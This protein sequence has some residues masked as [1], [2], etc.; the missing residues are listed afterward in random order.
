MKFPPEKYTNKCPVCRFPSA[1]RP[2]GDGIRVDCACCGDFRVTN[3]AKVFLPQ[4]EWN[5]EQA[6]RVAFFLRKNPGFEINT[7]TISQL[8]QLRSLDVSEKG[9]QLLL[10]LAAAYPKPGDIISQSALEVP[11]SIMELR[12]SKAQ[13]SYEMRIS[14]DI[15]DSLKMLAVSACPDEHQLRWLVKNYLLDLHY[16]KKGIADGYYEISL[17]GWSLINRLNTSPVNSKQGFVAMPFADR[18]LPLFNDALY[19]GI[20]NAGYEPVRIDR[21]EHNNRIDDEIIAGI[22]RSR[23]VVADLSMHRGGIYFEAGYALGLGLP[24]VWTV[25]RTAL[26][27]NEVHFDNRQYN[28]LVWEEGKYDD[29][30]RRLTNRIEATIG[31]PF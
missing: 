31:R 21:H 12:R 28:F 14:K 10:S 6:F 3:M 26:D 27:N 24:V 1:F 16:L 4:K 11:G 17:E 23:F 7:K 29:L 22:R 25:E 18:F 20:F 19:P 13:A 15:L 5:D 2:D 9:L 30:A 8:E